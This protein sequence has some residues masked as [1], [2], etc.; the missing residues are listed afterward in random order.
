MIRQMLG[1][2]TA[3][4]RRKEQTNIC[5]KVKEE[6]KVKS[7]LNFMLALAITSV[8]AVSVS[9]DDDMN[10]KMKDILAKAPDA[11]FY[12]VT[13]DDIAKWIKTGKKDF[14]VIDVRSRQE[15]YKKGHI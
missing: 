2:L 11:G 12:Q 10:R 4:R 14:V 5:E 15:E 3:G 1:A 8:F 9:A 6:R 7:I 13:A